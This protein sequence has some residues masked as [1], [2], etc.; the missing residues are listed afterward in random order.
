[1]PTRAIFHCNRSL[2]LHSFY[3]SLT[4]FSLHGLKYSMYYFLL[5]HAAAPVTATDFTKTRPNDFTKKGQ[6]SVSDLLWIFIHQSGSIRHVF[7]AFSCLYNTII[8]ED[9]SKLTG[10]IFCNSFFIFHGCVKTL[11]SAALCRGPDHKTFY[12]QKYI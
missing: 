3:Q 9:N 8:Q 1:M 6:S 10:Q 11:G 5:P 7:N 2:T 12:Y 4:Q